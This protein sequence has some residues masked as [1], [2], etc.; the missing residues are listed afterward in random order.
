M[1][2]SVSKL[3]ET[4]LHELAKK[5][6]VRLPIWWARYGEKK[7]NLDGLKGVTGRNVMIRHIKVYAK[8]GIIRNFYGLFER[9]LQKLLR[10]PKVLRRPLYDMNSLLWE[11]SNGHRTFAEICEV[12]DDVFQEE[13]APV[14]ERTAASIKKFE[15]L[16][17]MIILD[18]EFEEIW[19]TGPGFDIKG[20]LPIPEEILELDWSEEE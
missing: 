12:L 20:E 19:P 9:L 6:P 2:E 4:E 10:A 18:S 14:H 13:I 16:G 3:V 5:Y 1:A 15:T 8:G 17:M 7:D 11:L